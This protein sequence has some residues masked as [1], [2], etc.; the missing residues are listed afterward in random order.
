ML[1]PE[2]RPPFE[3]LEH[4]AD[5]GLSVRGATLE[6]LLEHAIDGLVEI[7]G[8]RGGR[9]TEEHHVAVAVNEEDMGAALVEVLDEVIFLIDRHQARIADA[10][11]TGEGSSLTA[12][13]RWEASPEPPEGTELK[14]ATYHLLAVKR[15]EGGY[16]ATVYF[17]V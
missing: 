9:G 17:D 10:H 13:L 8:V 6:Q 11:V 2:E 1:R 5:I 3:I 14:A 12:R 16:E 7:I 15:V 4:T